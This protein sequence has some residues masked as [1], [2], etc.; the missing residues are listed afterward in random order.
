[1]W[2]EPE[3]LYEGRFVSFD[4]VTQQPR[5]VQRPHPPIVIGGQSPATYR[6]VIESGN[7]WYGWD[8]DPEQTARELA[9]L[10]AAGERYE[11]PA[12]LGALSDV[13]VSVTPPELPDVDTARRYA[14]AGVHRLVVQPHTMDGTAMD[15]LIERVGETLISRV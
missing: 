7:G 12:T 14:E 1:L 9:R 11:R 10:R 2:Q 4:G 5:P 15:E 6:R 8:L 13:E 3:P